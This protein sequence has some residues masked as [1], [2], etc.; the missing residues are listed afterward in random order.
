MRNI[1]FH[2]E[3]GGQLLARTG[4]RVKGPIGP[5]LQTRSEKFFSRYP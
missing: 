1:P 4:L 3:V 2:L 5:F